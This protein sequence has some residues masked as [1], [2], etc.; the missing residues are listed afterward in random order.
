MVTLCLNN[1]N[2]KLA[3]NKIFAVSTHCLSHKDCQSSLVQSLIVET[4]FLTSP[5]ALLT[6]GLFTNAWFSLRISFLMQFLNCARWW[7]FRNVQYSLNSKMKT[8]SKLKPLEREPCINAQIM[9]LLKPSKLKR[10]QE[11]RGTWGKKPFFFYTCR[12]FL[13]WVRLNTVRLVEIIKLVKRN[14]PHLAGHPGRWQHRPSLLDAELRVARNC[15]CLCVNQQPVQVPVWSLGVQPALFWGYI[16]SLIPT[17]QQWCSQWSQWFSRWKNG[18]SPKM[19]HV[20]LIN[21]STWFFVFASR[22]KL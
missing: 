16:T 10:L 18:R 2:L 22:R 7:H 21:H 3:L 5:S 6:L 19:S 14:R 13:A 17:V 12:L 4:I 20:T 9:L 8:F 1:V 15:F 11:T